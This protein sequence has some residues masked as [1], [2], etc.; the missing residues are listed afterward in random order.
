M[1]KMRKFGALA[2]AV[3]MCFALAVTASAATPDADYT[4]S[5]QGMPATHNEAMFDYVQCVSATQIDVYL[6][7]PIQISGQQGEITNV[8]MNGTV[9]GYSVSF[10]AAEHC[11]SITC[12]ASAENI[13]V[14]VSV[15]I[16]I[17]GGHQGGS[18]MN[19]TLIVA[20]AE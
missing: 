19:T 13:A 16:A 1:T 4:A 6:N 10:D 9:D 5:F 12:P 11:I 7:S 15:T 8:A 18:T 20:P 14:P 2:M 3:V 17:S